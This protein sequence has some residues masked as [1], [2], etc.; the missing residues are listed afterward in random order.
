ML[1]VEQCGTAVD[2]DV[3]EEG[4]VRGEDFDVIYLE[5]LLWEP[6]SDWEDSFDQGPRVYFHGGWD[7]KTVQFHI[8]SEDP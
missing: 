5:Y 7:G 3:V 2:A 8:L 1:R 4:C 6:M